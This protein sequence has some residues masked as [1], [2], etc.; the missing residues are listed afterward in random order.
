MQGKDGKGQTTAREKPKG[1]NPLVLLGRALLA[2]LLPFRLVGAM[3]HALVTLLEAAFKVAL[4][5]LKIPFLAAST[6]LHAM[7]MVA[8]GYGAYVVIY[9]V[10]VLSDLQRGAINAALWA[11]SKTATE[12]YIYRPRNTDLWLP[13]IPGQYVSIGN[14]AF[15]LIA[16]YF[17]LRMLADFLRP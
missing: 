5:L 4:L 7:S 16:A 12:F 1:F 9:D 8:A 6:V 3:L 13:V 14:L 10:L 11:A 17:V 15:T 2:V